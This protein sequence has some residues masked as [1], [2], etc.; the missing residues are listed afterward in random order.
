MVETREQR[1]QRYDEYTAEM[2]RLA[3]K[4]KQTG[5]SQLLRKILELSDKCQEIADGWIAELNKEDAGS[6]GPIVVSI[7]VGDSGEMVVI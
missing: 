3:D 7:L 6:E 4:Y 1:N 2:D 5:S